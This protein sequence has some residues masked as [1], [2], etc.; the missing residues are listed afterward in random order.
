[1]ADQPA[2]PAAAATAEPG[3]A[4]P[5]DA[6]DQALADDPAA[7]SGEPAEWTAPT[8][9][10]HEALLAAHKSEVEKERAKLHRA[11]EQAKKLREGKTT[12]GEPAA[13]GDDGG[14]PASGPDPQV[15]VWQNRAVRAAAKA[16]LL[17]RKA[18][19]DLVDLALARLK[20]NEIDFTD[21]GDPDLDAWIDELEEKYPKLF[22]IPAAAAA[23]AGRQSM[24]G[25][26]QG[27]AARGAG[28]PAK[29]RF[30]DLVLENSRRAQ[31]RR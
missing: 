17:N 13:E 21:D 2:T 12:P 6:L 3:E 26:D 7:G 1:M 16:E 22:N 14:S 9:E 29:K 15:A 18:D 30:G 20:P 28:T 11:R 31:G 27:R 8:R 19:P 23:P 25:V 24:G 4:D 10:E 5:L